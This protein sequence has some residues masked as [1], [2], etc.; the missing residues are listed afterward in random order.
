MKTRIYFSH[1]MFFVYDSSE[2]SPGNAWTD[3][4]SAQGFARR[5][6]TANVATLIEDGWLDVDVGAAEALNECER[7]V[8][9]SVLSA[10]G[11]ISISGIDPEDQVLWRGRPGWVRVSMGQER[12]ADEQEV[13]L[14]FVAEEAAKE[15]S[16]RV[17]ERGDWVRRDFIEAAEPAVY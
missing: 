12:S 8:A 5:S 15:E 11:A 7:V 14:V 3:D 10:S 17:R 16:T 1:G 2:R 4:H 6:T 9:V 13:R